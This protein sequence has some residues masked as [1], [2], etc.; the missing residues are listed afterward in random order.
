MCISS[1]FYCVLINKTFFC[2]TWLSLIFLEI[3]HFFILSCLSLNS[4]IF[5]PG[6]MLKMSLKVLEC[7]GILNKNLSGHH[8]HISGT[9]HHVTVICGKHLLDDNIFRCFFYFFKILIFGV[10]RGVKGQ[11]MVQNDKKLCLSCSISEEP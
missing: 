10:H 11:K 3:V 4:L 9:I 8:V 6:K 1:Y 7:S 5:C 2:K